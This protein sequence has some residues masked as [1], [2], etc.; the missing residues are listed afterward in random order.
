[1]PVIAAASHAVPPHVIPQPLVRAAVERIFAGRIPDADAVRIGEIFA[2]SRIERRAF[3]MPPDWYMEPHPPSERNAVFLEKG[4]E[5][6]ERAGRECLKK[7]GAPPESVDL[8]I[9]VSTT[10]VAAPSPDSYLV[11]RLEMGPGTRR[12][13]VWGLGC[14]GGVAGVARALDYCLAHPRSRV[15]VTALETCSLNLSLSDLSKRNLVAASLFADGCAAV[16]VAGDESGF[17]G[18]RLLASRSRL[19]PDSARV[20]GWDVA[21]EGFRLVLSPAL[22]DIVRK[23]LAPLADD[24]LAEQGLS[25]EHI[26]HYLTHPGGAK[27]MDAVR[28]SLALRDGELRLTAETLRDYG[29][30]SSVSVL[31]VLQKWMEG[32]HAQRPGHGLMSAFGPGFSAELVL[33][34]A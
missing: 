33:L 9:F 11:R 32:G 19:F 21:D 8:V 6:L 1:M 4:L 20:M 5:L 18:P 12:L 30:L 27:V 13:P 26:V 15:L 22:P 34:R 7:A 29:N 17:A 14:A 16:L 24:F 31:V 2:N 28:D 25:R 23:E 10:G 3:V